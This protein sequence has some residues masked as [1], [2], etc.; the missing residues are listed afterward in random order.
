MTIRL[1]IFSSLPPERCVHFSYGSS[2]YNFET[3]LSFK[4]ILKQSSCFM[5]HPTSLHPFNLHTSLNVP[6]FG[7]IVTVL[8]HTYQL[9]RL[10]V[11]TVLIMRDSK[12]H[13]YFM[14]LMM[15]FQL[16]FILAMDFSLR[17]KTSDSLDQ[18]LIKLQDLNSS[19]HISEPSYTLLLFYLLIFTM[20]T[21]QFKTGFGSGQIWSKVYVSEPIL[22][23]GFRV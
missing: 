23:T 8:W 6:W 21:L 18:S 20:F 12:E 22:E 1:D 7:A 19:S 11:C 17:C 14:I 2:L 15:Q 9:S 3:V 16:A 4:I 10:W 5:P 13:L